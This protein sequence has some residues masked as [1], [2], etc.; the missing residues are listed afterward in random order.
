M[1]LTDSIARNARPAAKA[2]RMF[3]RDGLYLE[4]SPRGGKWWRL[5]TALR[6]TRA[7]FR[8]PPIRRPNSTAVSTHTRLTSIVADRRRTQFATFA[9]GCER[10]RE[11][12]C[13]LL[14]VTSV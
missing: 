6:P 12:N 10:R 13:D 8:S 1:L 11:R 4:V 5:K 14:H 9:A 7:H 2:V 3:D